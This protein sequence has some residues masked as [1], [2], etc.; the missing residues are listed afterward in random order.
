LSVDP[1]VGA[2]P[3]AE[4]PPV[5]VVLGIDVG[6]TV[7]PAGGVDAV[8]GVVAE[9]VVSV[10]PEAV[11]PEAVVP[12]A[13]VPDAGVAPAVAARRRAAAAARPASI[14]DWGEFTRYPL[15]CPRPAR[16]SAYPDSSTVPTPCCPT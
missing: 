13:V 12:E 3:V 9:A 14:A 2:Y 6:A 5:V 15:F 8:A 7:V 4:Y 11:V 10:V 1:P 16:I